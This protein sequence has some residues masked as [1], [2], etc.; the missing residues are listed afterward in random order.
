MIDKLGYVNKPP[1][2]T[3]VENVKKESA[4]APKGTPEKV[5]V[6]HT[7]QQKQLAESK[8]SELAAF[9][10]IQQRIKRG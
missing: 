9:G 5:E 4:P 10:S 8:S 1:T 6:S 7:M 3:D 2:L